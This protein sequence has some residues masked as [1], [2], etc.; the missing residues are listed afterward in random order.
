MNLELISQIDNKVTGRQNRIEAIKAKLEN[1]T[2]KNDRIFAE[3]RVN[4]VDEKY[5]SIIITNDIFF[6]TEKFSTFADLE[7]ASEL[8]YFLEHLLKTKQ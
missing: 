8:I 5:N 6:D 4:E 3:Y 2:Y 1:G 7:T